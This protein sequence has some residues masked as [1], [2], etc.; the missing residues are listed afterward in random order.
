M[1]LALAAV[2]AVSRRQ[3]RAALVIFVV[4]LGWMA[5]AVISA[6]PPPLSVARLPSDLDIPQPDAAALNGPLVTMQGDRR[7][8]RVN[9]PSQLSW[10]LTGSER[11]L[12]FEYGFIPD[13]YEHGGTNGAEFIVELSDASGKRSIFRK[14]LMPVSRAEDRKPQF[15]RVIL[16]PFSTGAS[17]ILRLDAGEGNDNAW[18]WLYVGNVKFRR[19]E[20][21]LTAQF[22]WFELLPSEAEAPS[23]LLYQSE[24][25]ATFLQL[26]V[27]AR[28][29][30]RLKGHERQLRFTYGLLPG[31][32]Q[33]GNRTDGVDFS[34]ELRENLQPPRVI[35]QRLLDPLNREMDRGPQR[36]ALK[37][38]AIRAG[39]RLEIVLGPGPA[40]NG[41]WDWAYVNRV[42]LD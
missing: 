31:A 21:F 32:F 29:V 40:N 3:W 42:N 35:F 5:R 7:F 12:S 39:S 4:S 24:G 9:A 25:R 28:L 15:S 13:A 33:N 18:D 23:A 8:L 20:H 37:L 11:T 14:L 26:N 38:P 22:P 17:L 41:A 2:R 1:L 6:P 36:S 30:F 16:P 34:V 10:L 27:P 19:S